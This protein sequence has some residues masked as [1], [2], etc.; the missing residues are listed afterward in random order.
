MSAVMGFAIH[1]N[2][3]EGVLPENGLQ[4]MQTMSLFYAKE[5]R[6]A[7]ALPNIAGLRA[8]IVDKNDLEG[9]M[10]QTQCGLW[11]QAPNL[12]RNFK[13]LEAMVPGLAWNQ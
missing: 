12:Y 6:F 1:S 2:S 5:N 10:S 8:L 11:N 3:F 4:V 9:K 13:A 7:G